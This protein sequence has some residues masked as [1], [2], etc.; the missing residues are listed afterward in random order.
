[1][2]VTMAVTIT[3]TM[4]MTMAVTP[5][6][7][8]WTMTVIITMSIVCNQKQKKTFSPGPISNP[9]Y[10]NTLPDPAV[11]GAEKALRTALA[12]GIPAVL[13]ADVAPCKTLARLLP[14]TTHAFFSRGSSAKLGPT[15]ILILIGAPRCPPLSCC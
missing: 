7:Q 15:L 2:T 1:M 5:H 13:D 11:Q 4:A 3:M 9:I 10:S 14:H 12:L 6:G 8:I